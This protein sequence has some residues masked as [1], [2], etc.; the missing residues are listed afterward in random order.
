MTDALVTGA[1]AL[2]AILAL[3]L[4]MEDLG[5]GQSEDT[6][7]VPPILHKPSDTKSESQGGG[8]LS[9]VQPSDGSKPAS[10]LCSLKV[11]DP[12]FPASA[13][14]HTP[15]A[16]S[17]YV[18][19]SARC[20]FHHFLKQTYSPYTFASAAFQ[21]TEAQATGDWSHYYGS[22]VPGWGKRLGSTLAD[23][24]SRRFIQ[25]Y[26]LSTI[27]HQDP[28]YFPSNKRRLVPRA[29]YAATRVV[30]GKTDEGRGTFN[31]AEFLG[32]LFTSSLQNAYYPKPDRT[33]GD[34]LSRFAGALSSDATGN[35]LREFTPDLKRL[36]RKHAPKEIKKIEQKLPVPE[37]DKP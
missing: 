27:L 19:L 23:T 24:E 25:G 22:G 15:K 35:L 18:P 16:S 20:K 13:E 4:M 26:A 3:V 30:V 7:V 6:F 17:D 9:L 12:A 32:V 28:R 34:T 10:D 8:N 33:L 5:Y 21:A 1:S 36:F 29:W 31:S 14:P 2:L 37:D 11:P